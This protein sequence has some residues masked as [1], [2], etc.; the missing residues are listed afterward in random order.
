[1]GSYY[2]RQWHMRWFEQHLRGGVAVRDLCDEVVGFALAGPRSRALLQRLTDQ[3][4]SHQALGFMACRALDVGLVRAWVGRL[5]VVGELGYEIHCRAGEHATL[6]RA[7]LAAGRDLGVTEFGFAAMNTLRLEKSFGIWSREFTQDYRPG[8]TGMDRWIAFDKPDFL[9]R[10]AALAER[11]AGSPRALAT[12]EVEALDADASGYE[13]VWQGGRRVGFVTSGG[14]G[15]TVG[16]S[17]A[18]AYVDRELAAIG[19][20]LA[21]HIVGDLRPCRVIAPSPHDPEGK[22]LRA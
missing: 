6:R 13:P 10:A 1:M 22:R 20:E 11:T 21:V 2:L 9:G 5:S 12:L 14:Y 16:K 15:H 4:V 3:D 7:L 19:T 8:E 17:L 18:M